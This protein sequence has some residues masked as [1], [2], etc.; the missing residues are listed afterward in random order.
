MN[1]N[2]TN[3]NYKNTLTDKLN[4]KIRP[5]EST[6]QSIPLTF[7]IFRDKIFSPKL[8]FFAE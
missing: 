6:P 7:S 3:K 1:Q 4:D 5:V 2:Q 8:L